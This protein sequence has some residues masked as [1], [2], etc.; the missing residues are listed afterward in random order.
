MDFINRFDNR[1]DSTGTNSFIM[2]TQQKRSNDAKYD[3]EREVSE[4]V[5]QI[6]QVYEMRTRSLSENLKQLYSLVSN[7][8]LINTMKRD[9]CSME[10]ANQRVKEI[11]E[12]FLHSEREYTI[13]KIA[14]QYSLL[15][16]EYQ[17]LLTELSRVN[18]LLS[19]FVR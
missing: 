1:L 5:A 3:V 4:R 2:T 13:E 9:N 12:D 10:F 17:K 18:F 7:D 6:K 14:S 11:I 15:K 16:N 19:T 8:Q